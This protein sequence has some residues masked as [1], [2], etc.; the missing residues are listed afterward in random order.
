[1]GAHY[2]MD[3]MGGRTL[4]LYDMAHLLAN[5]PEYMGVS[6]RGAQPIKGFQSAVKTTRAELLASLQSECG[7][8]IEACAKEDTE[9]FNNSAA[10]EA[11]HDVTQTYN[12]PVVYP[13]NAGILEDVEKLAPKAG[14]LLAQAFPSLSP[15]RADKILTETKGPGGGFLDNGSEFGV[16][17]RLNLYA[18]GRC[19]EQIAAGK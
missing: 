7:N 17:S 3:V 1:M 5:D 6:V 18:A 8:A 14:Y 19:T 16:Y 11:F 2:T 13:K 10:D 9:R 15:E 12:L 4:A